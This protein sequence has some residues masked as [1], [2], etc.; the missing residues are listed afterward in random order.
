MG[1][2]TLLYKGLAMTPEEFWAILH[3]VPE[4]VTPLYRLYYNDQGEPLFYS[5]ED[6]PGNYIDIDAKIFAQS[7]SH[8]RVVNGQLINLTTR[9][10]FRKLVPA[11]QGTACDTRDV[12]VVVTEQEPHIKWTVKTYETD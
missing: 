4:V 3:D 9:K 12:C 5:Q 8:V 7:P 10:V 6:L 1:I 2:C 11:E